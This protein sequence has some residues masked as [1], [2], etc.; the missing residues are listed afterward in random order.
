M[1]AGC[2]GDPHKG[3]SL[4]IVR[5]ATISEMVDAPATVTARAAA[6][7][8]APADGR[9]ALLVTGGQ[10]VH[11]GTIVAVIDSPS[12][13]Q[14]LAQAR[15]AA[16]AVDSGSPRG[17]GVDLT[18]VQAQTDAA[19][20]TAFDQAQAA[21]AKIADP[22]ARAAS[23]RQLSAAEAQYAQAKE[24]ARL[25]VGQF[26]TGLA[27]L[28]TALR[29]L[30]VAQRVQ[31][32]AAVT[33]AQSAVDS[34]T[35]RAPIAGTVQLGGISSAGGGSA[36]SDLL[37]QLPAAAQGATAGA[38]AGQSGGTAA[39]GGAAPVAGIARG[40]LVSPGTAVVTVLDTST[41]ALSA[42]VDETDVLLVKP[43]VMA[44]VEL[45]AVP[46]ATYDATVA[47]VDLSPTT[48]S[49]GG[50]SYGVR[51]S[52]GRGRQADATAAAVPRPGMS[53][54]AHLVVRTSRDAVAVPASAVV[55]SG[56]RDAVWVVEAGSAR[57]RY[58]TVG[59]QGEDT[60]AIVDGVKVG[61]EVVVAGAE[62]VHSGQ[63]LP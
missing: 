8:T 6:T 36:L 24:Q 21:L 17:S 19:A 10:Q 3:I 34:L 18:G 7:L 62:R 26:N 40:S 9:V 5:T 33:A 2:S 46:G 47:S 48:S 1:L 53:A 14:R 22:A 39:Q 57:R 38:A 54:V 15:Q 32:Q 44:R 63:K 29:S 16:A 45:D 58:V 25:T 11:A 35:L 55:R 23:Q 37:G 20:K 42:E 30:T 49:G 50:V 51:L 60:V 28:G 52:L 41:L 56:A 31:A 43:G 61:D 13:Q 27:G 12:A 4:A 59:T